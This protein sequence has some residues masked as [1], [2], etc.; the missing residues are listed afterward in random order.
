MSQPIT[1]GTGVSAGKQTMRDITGMANFSKKPPAIDYEPRPAVVVPPK[2]A[3]L[4]PPGSADV[5]TGDWP[6][7]PD[8][9]RAAS[10][11]KGPR[12]NPADA[13][14]IDPDIRMRVGGPTTVQWYDSNKDPAATAKGTDA[15]NAKALK[16]MAQV[17]AGMAGGLDAN[18]NPVRATLT[19]PP[20]DYRMPDPSAP[21]EFTDTK[22]KS[23]WR[24]PWQ[25]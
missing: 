17:K 25:H 3:A 19:E 6:N 13:G 7:D 16:L 1:Y 5:S 2:D 23:K 20:P 10:L 9:A 8:V 4:P 14:R 11:S 21:T 12:L 15:Q 22:K 24:W 18:G